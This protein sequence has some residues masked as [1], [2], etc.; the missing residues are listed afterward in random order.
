MGSAPPGSPKAA[1]SFGR[2]STMLWH[3][4]SRIW[5]SVRVCRPFSKNANPGSPPGWAKLTQPQAN[6]SNW[7]PAHSPAD[8]R[9][10]AKQHALPSASRTTSDLAS[11]AT[12]ILV[13]RSIA[14]DASQASFRRTLFSKLSSPRLETLRTKRA[15]LLTW[16]PQSTRASTAARGPPAIATQSSGVTRSLEGSSEWWLCPLPAHSASS[17]ATASQSDRW[18]RSSG[19]EPSART[20]RHLTRPEASAAIVNG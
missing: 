10:Q 14:E 19:A 3:A 1:L 12:A 16:S 6:L 17:E 5:A 15:A 7:I 13:P 9:S 20:D 18:P 4:S 11:A 2:A 8:P